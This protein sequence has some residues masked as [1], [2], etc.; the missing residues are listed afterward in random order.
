[1][2]ASNFIHNGLYSVKDNIVRYNALNGHLYLLDGRFFGSVYENI[3]TKIIET[4][5]ENGIWADVKGIP[6]TEDILKANARKDISPD[7]EIPDGW[8]FGNHIGMIWNNDYLDFGLIQIRYV[9]ELQHTLHIC[10]LN[11]INFK[12]A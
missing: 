2:K 10:G 11:D 9:H 5:L 1:M 8:V 4:H 6:L 3:E 12:I 7:E